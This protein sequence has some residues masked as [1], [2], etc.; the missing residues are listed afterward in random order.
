M[1]RGSIRS[2]F[3]PAEAEEQKN[4]RNIRT[5]MAIRTETGTSQ[6]DTL[7]PLL[8]LP[9]LRCLQPGGRGCKYGCLSKSLHGD[10]I[11][12]ASA[13]VNAA[14]HLCKV[15]FLIIQAIQSIVPSKC[16]D[17][18]NVGTMTHMRVMAAAQ[19]PDC[20][21]VQDK[22]A[23]PVCIWLYISGIGRAPHP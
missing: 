15:L 21:I 5:T 20:G 12:S 23:S 2:T 8:S 19:L 22:R 9:L 14:T 1:R 10:H 3:T 7:S 17:S 16:I 11:T 18:F 13:Y 4:P 6:G